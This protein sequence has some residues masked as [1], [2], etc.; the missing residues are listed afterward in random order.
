MLGE[1]RGGEE[2]L[3]SYKNAGH[4][5]CLNTLKGQILASKVVPVLNF[6]P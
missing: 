5:F 2:K 6:A 4:I 1:E 3:R